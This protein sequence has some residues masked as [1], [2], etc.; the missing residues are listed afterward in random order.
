[1]LSLKASDTACS[2][3]FDVWLHRPDTFQRRDTKAI[4]LHLLIESSQPPVHQTKY[5]TST[6]QLSVKTALTV[7][8]LCDIRLLVYC[9]WQ[10]KE[11]DKTLQI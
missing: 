4:M 6:R 5:K 9:I 11:M 3:V 8:I 7:T 1:M 10:F 2:R